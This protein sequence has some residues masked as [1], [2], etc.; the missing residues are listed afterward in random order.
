MKVVLIFRDAKDDIL[1]I[2]GQSMTIDC[3]TTCR[4][5]CF[6]KILLDGSECLAWVRVEEDRRFALLKT[7]SP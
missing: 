7:E 1:R 2:R 5:D 4:S 6:E 3:S